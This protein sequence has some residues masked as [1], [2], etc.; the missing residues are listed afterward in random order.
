MG[1]ADRGQGV[2]V[3]TNGDRGILLAQE[4]VLAV[5]DV[6]GWPAPDTEV[7]TPI[8]L[9]RADLEEYTGRYVP[10]GPR[11]F[12]VQVYLEGDRLLTRIP[13]EEPTE[14]IA[15]EEDT[16]LS[17]ENRRRIVFERGDDG[18]VTGISSPIRL[19]RLDG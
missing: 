16:F 17:I 2:A 3:M 11:S 10:P 18:Q 15:V 8:P 13:G 4:I 19:D 14:L 6:Y 7:I 5:A 1:F 9:G 12:A